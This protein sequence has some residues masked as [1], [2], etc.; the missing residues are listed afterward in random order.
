MPLPTRLRIG[1]IVDRYMLA[2]W[3]ADALH[4]LAREA[5]LLVYSCNSTKQAPRRLKHANYY[6]LNLFTVRNRMTRRIP[7]QADLPVERVG[8]FDAAQEGNWQQLPPE[9]IEQLRGDRL[10][11][12]IK[13]G[14][15]LLRV[16]P[17]DELPIP[18]LSY[19]HG[20]PTSFRGRPAGFYEMLA[21]APIM[22][23]VVQRLSNNL[24]AGDIV[25]FAETK[26]AAHSY[27]ST[28]I[29]SY[30]HSPAILK[31][32]ITNCLEGQSW[33]PEHWGKNYRL[34][35]NIAVLKFVL[36]QWRHALARLFY[37]L[38]KEKEWNV[39]TVAIDSDVSVDSVVRSLSQRGQW[40][41]V[42]LPQGYRFLADPFFHPDGG[43]LVE[44]LNSRSSRGE[45][46]HLDGEE[47]RRIS[48]RG[49][50]YSYPATCFDGKQWHIFPEISEW[51]SAEA[52]V[53]G[54]NS[55]ARPTKLRLPGRPALLDPT[56]F[57]HEG[58]LYLF[59]NLAK[60]GPTVLRLWTADR[61][62]G[63][64]AEHPSSPIR[65]SPHG[66]RMAGGIFSMDGDLV[67]VGQDLRRGYG[68]G[69]GLFR[70]TQLDAK[71]YDEELIRD[72]RFD[73]CKGPHTLNLKE[74]CAAFDFYVEGFSVLA[75]IRRL[76]ERRAART[77]D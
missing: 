11:A 40:R 52:F 64:F 37:G 77:S 59:A 25:A 1:V 76:I 54:S 16:P 73:H 32:A 38:F 20:D 69:L 27:R 13:F 50:H 12:I 36:K 17:E 23:Q 68:D 67:R 28:L 43:L 61:L 44:G 63:D 53:L 56:P 21:G 49:G 33:R 6:L 2:R 75:G 47:V 4:K 15:G 51:S 41:T 60:D 24:D 74:G 3:Q 48:D 39:A 62:A 42:P 45:I 26:V 9:L 70:I 18:I 55:L 46:L 22:G 66:S 10:D 65:I 19:H 8:E 57:H 58:M 5:D 14:M 34:P 71:R 72:F 29:E 7:W 30:R 31:R 35:S